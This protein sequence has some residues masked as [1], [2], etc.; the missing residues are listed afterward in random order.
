[1][2][3]NKT[4]CSLDDTEKWAKENWQ[5]TTG[6]LKPFA[7]A[8]AGEANSPDKAEA[9]LAEQLGLRPEQMQNKIADAAKNA[10]YC[11]STKCTP[12]E[13]L[14][15]AKEKG[16]ALPAPLGSAAK[17]LVLEQPSKNDLIPP[18]AKQLA[19]KLGA[20]ADDLMKQA[21]KRAMGKGFCM[22]DAAVVAF[23]GTACEDTSSSCTEYKPLCFDAKQGPIVR[24]RCPNTCAVCNVA[25]SE[26]ALTDLRLK[27]KRQT[28]AQ[29][30][31]LCTNRGVDSECALSVL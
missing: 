13:L 3:V 20:F 8:L 23:N 25:C 31:W 7:Q 6:P 29:I 24:Q 1:M 16:S 17:L 12:D 2:R 15:W 28:C 10:R 5:N 4:A 26:P 9:I 30:K 14:R 19:K 22:K 11:K 18:D 21:K 27:G